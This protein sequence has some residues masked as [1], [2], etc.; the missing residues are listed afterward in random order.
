MIDGS[1]NTK[2]FNVRLP[3]W[4]I[5]YIDQRSE[6]HGI[7]K[8]QVVVDALTELRN[9]ELHDLMRRGYEEMSAVDRRMAEDALTASPW[10]V[11][12]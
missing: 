10:G 4:A 11:S 7:T 8:T 9:R 3:I 12:E 5:D 6:E 1:P 2:P